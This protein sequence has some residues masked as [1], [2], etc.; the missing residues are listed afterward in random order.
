[1]L[2]VEGCRDV[3]GSVCFYL[4]IQC[5]YVCV[6]NGVC[7]CVYVCVCVCGC[8]CVCYF[9]TVNTPLLFAEASLHHPGAGTTNSLTYISGHSKIILLIILNI[10]RIL[11]SILTTYHTHTHTHTRT[12]T[13]AHTHTHTHTHTCGDT[14]THVPKL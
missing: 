5:V 2:C 3:S 14:G 6:C 12:D 10:I 11:V 13:H 7:V 1:I 4:S 9:C 8:V